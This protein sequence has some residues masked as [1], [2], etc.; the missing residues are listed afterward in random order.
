MIASRPNGTAYQGIPA[1]GTI[2]RR[3]RLTFPFAPFSGEWVNSR[4]ALISSRL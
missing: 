3:R 4:R 1:D 2:I